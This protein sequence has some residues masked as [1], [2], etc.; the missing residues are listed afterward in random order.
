M[1]EMVAYLAWSHNWRTT[2]Q[3]LVRRKSV[4]FSQPL[5][6]CSPKFLNEMISPTFLST[7]TPVLLF[8]FS[9]VL[10]SSS[11]LTATDPLAVLGRLFLHL[12]PLPYEYTVLAGS[13]EV[14]VSTSLAMTAEV[15]K[16]DLDGGVE[17]V[18]GVSCCELEESSEADESVLDDE[19]ESDG[20]E[21]CVT[22]DGGP[23][24]SVLL[25]WF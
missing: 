16:H 9:L 5:T 21:W 6:T 2:R 12:D 1:S 15:R 7:N 3:P 10:A 11:P 14:R 18:V 8:P 25:S 13:G 19:V 17:E 24:R 22:I 4:Q 23:S 20:V